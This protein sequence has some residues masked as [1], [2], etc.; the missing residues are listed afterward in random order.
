METILR[1]NDIVIFQ[2]LFRNTVIAV[3]IFVRH[4]VILIWF[5]MCVGPFVSWSDTVDISI[6]MVFGVVISEILREFA[7]IVIVRMMIIV[8][9][10]KIP[11]I[12]VHIMSSTVILTGWRI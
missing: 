2:F 6:G 12:N 1:L 10:V 4:V 5:V 7:S 9:S 3:N 11:T 8:T